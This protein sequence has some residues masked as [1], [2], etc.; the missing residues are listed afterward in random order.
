MTAWIDP[1]GADHLPPSWRARLGW[2]SA[3]G[4]LFQGLYS[5]C[6]AAA[7]RAGISR[8]I[9]TPWDAGLP[10]LPWMLL[11][12]MSSVPLLV[13]AFLFTPTRGSLRA[14]SQRCAVATA[15]ATWVFAVWPLRVN[16]AFR[17]GLAAPADPLPQALAGLLLQLDGPYNQWP[18]LHAAYAVILW[19]ALRGRMPGAAGRLA[20]GGWLLLLAA[21]TVF[22]GQHHLPD[23]A[24]GLA[25]GG[26]VCWRLPVMA[27]AARVALA[28]AVLSLACLTL[29]L[30]VLPLAPC[31]WAAA[32]CGAVAWAYAGRRT[33]FL[34]KRGGSFPAWVWGLYGPYLAGYWLIWCWVRWRG[35]R[36][37][38]FQA[39]AP[40]VWVGRRL[41]E[42]EAAG[43][44]P[45]CRVI[46]L[47][48]ELTVPPELRPRIVFTGALLDLVT[49]SPVEL[50]RIAE[51]IDAERLR[52]RPVLLHCA[53]GYRRSREALQAWAARPT[54]PSPRPEDLL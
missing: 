8:D 31:L 42:G 27:E 47:A 29:G 39:A 15:L 4:L 35:R 11:P 23:L 44:P 52:G 17:A 10:H 12:Y 21:S 5:A 6:Q 40:G 25:L 33:G 49:P 46:D 38:P 19:P 43:L 34:H 32:C 22:T 20:W 14:L 37:A 26:L 9:A 53:M 28:Y 3:N 54:V 51:A 16:E 18:S 36:E 2:M 7:A 24:G 13:L 50:A 48:S 1:S 41:T 45:G 30:T